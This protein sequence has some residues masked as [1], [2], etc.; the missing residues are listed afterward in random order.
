[1][2]RDRRL[3]VPSYQ[4]QQP[5]PGYARAFAVCCFS[6]LMIALLSPLNAAELQSAD[7]PHVNNKAREN[8]M[9]Y[10]YANKNRAFA[11]APGGAWAWQADAV[12]K[13]QAEQQALASCQQYTQQKCVLYA[14]NDQ[15]VFDKQ[16]WPT[17]WGPY[18][19]SKRASELE[20]GVKV[21]QKFPD[22]QWLDSN[23]EP[24]SISQHMGKVIFLHFWGSWC[25]PCMREF[26]TLKQLQSELAMLGD[27]VKM[28]ALQLR[29]PFEESLLWAKANN[30]EGMPLYDSGVKDSETTRLT[31]SNGDLIFDRKVARVFPSSYVLDKN[32][33]VIF[34]HNG[35]VHDWLEYIDFFRHA[36]AGPGADKDSDSH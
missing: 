26:P 1:M 9:Q 11:I 27:G 23:S 18:H 28:V 20:I 19:D 17:L 13:E 34:V 35:P 24:T 4:K 36:T 29:E 7:I 5:S 6:F 15:L 14:V 31:L 25:P 3:I 30:F 22:L 8:F 21:G 16:A 33:I 10:Q 32:G 2:G 12:S